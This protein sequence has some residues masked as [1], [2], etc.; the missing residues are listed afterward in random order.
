MSGTPAPRNIKGEA[1]GDL[2]G[3][4]VLGEAGS[5][6]L[7]STLLGFVA[8]VM[9]ALGLAG[10]GLAPL[11][12]AGLGL[13]PLLM[14]GLGLTLLGLALLG[15]APIGLALLGFA[16]KEFAVMEAR[17]AKASGGGARVARMYKF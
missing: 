7:G 13:T 15:L 11:G 8:V 12:M 4:E 9:A 14:P 6:I 10:L 3:V 2:P 5:K 1:F 17:T 16:P